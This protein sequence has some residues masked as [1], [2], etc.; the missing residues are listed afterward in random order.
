MMIPAATRGIGNQVWSSLGSYTPTMLF[1]DP[2]ISSCVGSTRNG[3]M[4]HDSAQEKCIP[5]RKRDSPS[6]FGKHW[7]N[8]NINGPACFSAVGS[9]IERSSSVLKQRHCLGN[10]KLN[11]ILDQLIPGT[12]YDCPK[13]PSLKTEVGI[14]SNIATILPVEIP[15]LDQIEKVSPGTYSPEK[16][17][18][19]L[20]T[21]R[22]RKMKKHQRQKAKA[23]NYARLQNIKFLKMKRKERIFNK[24]LDNIKMKGEKF[25]AFKEIKANLEYAR[26]K[27][28][29]V[30]IFGANS[31]SFGFADILK[32]KK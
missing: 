9:G 18:A 26:H 1:H 20:V 7:N 19:I 30:D 5:I 24:M 11:S 17:A 25:D 2:Q 15:G 8:I 28:Y 27:G 21:I 13:I 12:R 6:L 4:S 32:N 16:Q 14:P 22:K 3:N 23:R 29:F 31:K 10:G